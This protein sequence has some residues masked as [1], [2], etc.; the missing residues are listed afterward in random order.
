MS[1]VSTRSDSSG[2]LEF[3]GSYNL[4]NNYSAKAEGFFMDADI[5]KAHVAFE[6]MKE[7]RD[8]HIAYKC[9][10]GSHQFSMMQTLSPKLLGGFEMYYIVSY[11]FIPNDYSPTRKKCISV[12]EAIT[13]STTISS[14]LNTCLLQGKKLY[15]SAM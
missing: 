15:L 10:G 6:I 5:Q 3:S 8:S 1:F 2:K 4:G 14:S 9:G 13:H 12:S 11:S 7:F